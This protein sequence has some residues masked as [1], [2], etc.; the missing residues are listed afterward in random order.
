MGAD[1]SRIVADLEGICDGG[2]GVGGPGGVVVS[3]NNPPIVV[4]GVGIEGVVGKLL[5]VKVG[6]WEGGGIGRGWGGR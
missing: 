4:V 6:I 3:G 5:E 1:S 2:A